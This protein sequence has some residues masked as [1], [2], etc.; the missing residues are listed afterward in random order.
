MRPSF[1][2]EGHHRKV[3]ATVKEYINSSQ[4]FVSPQTAGSPRAVGDALELLI[5]ERFNA[6]LGD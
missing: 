1:Y 3:A 2:Y 5:A 6:L 4:D